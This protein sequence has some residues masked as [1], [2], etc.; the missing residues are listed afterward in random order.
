[1]KR[2][3]PLM[4][5]AV[6]ILALLGLSCYVWE[7][8]KQ[9]E[10]QAA[11][12]AERHLVV[13]SA[14]PDDVNKGLADEFYKKTGWR[15][16]VQTRTDGQIRQLLKSPDLASPP[17]M[18][19]ASEQVLQDQKKDS[20][21]QAYTSP[22]TD[23][24]PSSLKDDGGYWTGLWLNPM[25]FIISS[26]Y[27]ERNGLSPQTWD[28]LLQDPN[29]TLVFPDLAAMDMAG[30]FLCSFVEMRGRDGAGRYLRELQ[31]HVTSYS[32][33]M[34][35]NVRIV[36]GGDADAGVVDAAMAR[37]Y[38]KDGAPIY[39]IYPRD[40]TS[41]WLTGAAITKW[42]TDGEMAYAFLNWL[43]SDD[44]DGILRRNHIYLTY[45]SDTGKNV[46]DAKGDG[47]ALFPVKKQYTAEGRRSLQDWWI[48][49]VRFGKEP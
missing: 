2:Y 5:V 40:G 8:Q 27:Y 15:V 23:A 36:A 9:A 42:C 19:I 34:S 3:M 12:E 43:F 26:S 30:D 6:F 22:Q 33:S 16:Q 13:Y 32:Q 37:Q 44:V 41:Y 10:E 18:I 24:V 47:L 29:L 35:S 48:K 7:K 4:A 1:M 28:E 11:Y 45:T 31:R 38:S 20:M 46:L 21:L 25:V 17:D 39:I 49:S 14:M